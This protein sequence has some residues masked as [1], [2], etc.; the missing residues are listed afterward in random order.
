MAVVAPEGLLGV[1][2]GRLDF[3]YTVK[4]LD[5]PEEEPMLSVAMALTKYVPAFFQA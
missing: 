4:P 1:L 2:G 5:Q 3:T